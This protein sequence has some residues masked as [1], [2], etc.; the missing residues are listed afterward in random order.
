[1]IPPLTRARVSLAVAAAAA[2]AA[3]LASGCAKPAPALPP[4]AQAL[5]GRQHYEAFKCWDCHGMDLAGTDKGPTLRTTAAHW[6]ADALVRFLVAPD[7]ALAADPRLTQISRAYAPVGM[8]AYDIPRPP[9]RE[10]ATYLIE[11]TR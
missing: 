11:A 5:P 4:S 7:S 1:M 8:P 6:Q 9:L 10:L 2:L 3:T